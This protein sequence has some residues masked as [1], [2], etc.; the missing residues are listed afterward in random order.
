MC[1][2]ETTKMNCY[3]KIVSEKRKWLFK[4]LIPLPRISK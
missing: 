4:V 1:E 3:Y 2:I